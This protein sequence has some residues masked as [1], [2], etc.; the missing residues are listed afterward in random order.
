MAKRQL[1]QQEIDEV[2][3]TA[4]HG[5]REPAGTPS[6][7]FDFRR[8]DRLAKSQLTAIHVLHEQFARSVASALSVYLRSYISG[9]LICVEQTTYSE[10]A[11][12]LPS[13]TC[14]VYVSMKPYD[15]YTVIEINQ[16]LLGAILELIMGGSCKSTAQLKREITELEQEILQGVFRLIAADLTAT[17]QPV[18]PIEFVVEIVETQPQL[19]RRFE[20]TEAVVAIAIEL[21]LEDTI[22][23]INVAIPSI[24]LKMMRHRFEQQRVGQGAKRHEINRAVEEKLTRELI[25]K[26]DC[27]VRGST[28]RLRD[29]VNLKVGQV[30]DF[31]VRFDEGVTVAVAGVPK[32]KGYPTA[33]GATMTVRIDAAGPN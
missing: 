30:I 23:M 20:R 4:A 6:V 11:E 19:S 26:V 21:R 8:L 25:L 9:T 24:T 13:P 17:W 31:G 16:C 14:M 10:F 22:G 1:S 32:F 2:F 12:S 15:G 29:V 18:G 5:G 7:G 28:I 33:S 3:Q 27:E